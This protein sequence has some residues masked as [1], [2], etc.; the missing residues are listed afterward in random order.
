[1][2]TL[3]ITLT[4]MLSVAYTYAQDNTAKIIDAY[5]QAEYDEM[6]NSNPGM[7]TLLN[8]YVSYGMEVI[9]MNPK[10]NSEPILNEIQL[11]S[12]IEMSVPVTDFIADYNSAN[13]NPL[14][15]KFFPGTDVQIYRLTG[16]NK[17]LLIHNQQTV[18][19][20]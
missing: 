8:K 7:I 1:M 11:R 10:Y 6:S 12:K 9:D 19:S 3:I 5:G 13:F 16:T 17:I 4:L 15:Y 2:K 20:K 14:D 18:L